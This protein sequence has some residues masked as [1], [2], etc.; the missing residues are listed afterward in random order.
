MD[1][2]CFNR[3]RLC[4]AAVLFLFLPVQNLYSCPPELVSGHGDSAASKSAVSESV[5]AQ[6]APVQFSP[7]RVGQ[8]AVS[9]VQSDLVQFETANFTV[10]GAT[11]IDLARK[12]CLESERL[13]R[14]LALIWLGESLPDWSSKCPIRVR[15]GDN[16]GAGGSTSF[17][18]Q[19]KEVYGWEMNIQG[20]AER[21]L[22]SVLPHEIT[23]TI[24]ASYLKEPVPRWLDEGAATCMEHHS[25]KENYRQMIRHFLKKDVK[26]CLPFNQMTTLKEYPDDVMPFYAQGFSVAEYLVTVGG[27]RLLVKFAKSAIETG[28]W[29]YALQKNYG[30]ASLGELQQDYWLNWVAAGSPVILSQVPDHLKLPQENNS[31]AQ[32]TNMTNN[33]AHHSPAA[34]TK[35]ITQPK[36]RT[37]PPNNISLAVYN[38]QPN[39][40]DIS[41]TKIQT[42]TKNQNNTPKPIPNNYKTA[43]EI[44]AEF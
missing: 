43:Y 21:I 28:D 5:V 13:R 29:N 24:F 18:F 31:I 3:I 19:N 22:D 34:N 25:E 14:D 12:F 6:F 33:I 23:H 1:A 39:N 32:S 42:T 44:L 37:P 4:L 16:L 26:K 17:V 8:A 36:H 11:S 7:D 41:A 2:L 40:K 20:S 27:H 15:V 38:Y 30:I 9:S 10:S 35:S